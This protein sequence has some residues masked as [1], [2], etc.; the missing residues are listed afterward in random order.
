MGI[1]LF[2]SLLIDYTNHRKSRIRTNELK[3]KLKCSK[4]VNL[5]NDHKIT[6]F[7]IDELILP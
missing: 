2:T 5:S 3:I 1:Y 6:P 7:G 4:Q